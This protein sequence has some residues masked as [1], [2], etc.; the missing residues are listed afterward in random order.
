MKIKMPSSYDIIGSK[1]KAVAIIEIPVDL[2]KNEKEIADEIMK[3]HKNV[4]AVL[5]KVS[6]RKDIFR[7]RDYKLLVG[8]RNTEV[9]HIEHGCLLKV[10]P[11][12]AY[13]S[14]REGTERMRIAS[15]VKPN[16]TIM[17]MFAGI[18]AFGVVIAKKQ[19]EIE[20]IIAI[21]MNP[22]AYEYMKE[23]LR[24]NK[25][26]HKIIPVLGDVKEKCKEWFDE[27]DR[28]IM[29]LPH[30]AVNFLDIAINCLKNRKGVIHLYLIEKENEVDKKAEELVDNLKKKT[31]KK[32]KYKINK[33]L[34]YAP[35]M[36][37]YCI[38][39]ELS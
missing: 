12:K 8:D 23:N 35:R 10:D 33:V 29:P 39:L 15:L 34:P 2:K 27:C 26:S 37:K 25:I 31:N 22:I 28:V 20:K 38:D 30:E 16:G 7:T 3:R 18:G 17:L 32:I 19:L 13:F 24:M 11:T 36:N 6:E 5:K 1:E 21:E 4:K 14:G 9:M